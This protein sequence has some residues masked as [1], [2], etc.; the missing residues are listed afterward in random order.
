MKIG[1]NIR[2]HRGF[3]I[4]ELLIVIVVIAILAAITIVAYNGI[5]DRAKASM[6]AQA[7][8]D[9]V[10]KVKYW[11][12]EQDTV[13]APSSLAVAGV[14]N[15]A[16]VEYQY[17]SGVDGAYCITATVQNKSYKVSNVNTTATP[18]GC[19]GHG[20]NGIAAVTNLTHAAAIAS[21]GSLSLY[22]KAGVSWNGQTWDAEFTVLTSAHGIRATYQQAANEQAAGHYTGSIEIGNPNTTSITVSI[23]L[24]DGPLATET[25]PAGQTRVLSVVNT[26]T[27]NPI[28]R[29]LDVNGHTTSQRILARNPT[30]IY[31]N[32]GQI[33]TY[34]GDSPNWVWTGTPKASSSTGPM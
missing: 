19:A 25:I 32:L 26:Q 10:K 29:F 2:A 8:S 23:D 20:Q 13:T 17:T 18:G 15:S 12:A 30:V 11:Q 14:S 33:S 24:G 5:Q 27:S 34:S 28:Y 7:L 16:S 6:A 1:G 3:T 31:G 9:T 22:N 21:R 4:V